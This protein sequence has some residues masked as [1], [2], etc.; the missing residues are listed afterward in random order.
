MHSVDTDCAYS[1]Q[2]N[3]KTLQRLPFPLC[4]SEEGGFEL[5]LEFLFLCSRSF[6]I[7]ALCCKYRLLLRF[8]IVPIAAFLLHFSRLW[9]EQHLQNESKTICKP[10]V[11]NL[12]ISIMHSY[13]FYGC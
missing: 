1:I 5:L 3:Y 13:N 10:L 8:V 6:A 7:V 2:H 9:S 4:P 11:E 12:I